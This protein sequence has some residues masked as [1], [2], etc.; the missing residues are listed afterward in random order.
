MSQSW[1]GWVSCQQPMVS[2]ARASTL[3]R[4]V[5]SFCSPRQDLPS[6]GS[7]LDYIH[8]SLSANSIYS[9]P[10]PEVVR[11]V[12]TEARGDTPGRSTING[13]GSDSKSQSMDVDMPASAPNRL[14][15]MADGRRPSPAPGQRPD[16]AAGNLYKT[17]LLQSREGLQTPLPSSIP[18]NLPLKQPPH[19]PRG[20]RGPE[21][22]PSRSDAAP[23][24]PPSAPSQTASAQELRETARQ[25][26]RRNEEQTDSRPLP[27]DSRGELPPSSSSL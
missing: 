22:W 27:P 1:L 6:K 13:N 2:N 3:E 8:P 15:D 20:H 11:R 17:A 10:R 18:A 23:M 14:D 5:A 9:V 26:I 4:Y 24:P 12:R 21:E 25:S 16:T 7:S 19:L